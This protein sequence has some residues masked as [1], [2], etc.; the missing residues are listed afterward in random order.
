M[1]KRLIIILGDQLNENSPVFKDACP[2]IDIVI[3]TEA[4]CEACYI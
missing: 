3:M 2:D 1:V 4:H